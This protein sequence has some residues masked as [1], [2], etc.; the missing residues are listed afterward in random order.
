MKII[1]KLKDYLKGS[2]Y[3]ILSIPFLIIMTGCFIVMLYVGSVFLN[4]LYCLLLAIFMSACGCES[5]DTFSKKS[6]CFF[7]YLIIILLPLLLLFVFIFRIP[8]I[9]KGFIIL[10]GIYMGFEMMHIFNNIKWEKKVLRNIKQAHGIRGSISIKE[11]ERLKRQSRF[12]KNAEEFEK[13]HDTGT[14]SFHI[15]QEEGTLVKSINGYVWV[16]Y[17]HDFPR[18][19]D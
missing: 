4:P 11:A 8:V 9:G 6:R 7:I 3:N 19:A 18:N 2:N 14:L 15:L 5:E 13:R 12:Y 1:S 16:D 17:M 10:A